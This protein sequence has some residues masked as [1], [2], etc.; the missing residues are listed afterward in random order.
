MPPKTTAARISQ[1]RPTETEMIAAKAEF[2]KMSGKQ[3]K[4]K[5]QSMMNFEKLYPDDD[6]RKSRG[7]VRSDYLLNFLVHQIR[8]KAAR[9]TISTTVSVEHTKSKN[10]TN[11]EW[12]SEQM[13]LKLGTT[14]LS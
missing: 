11:Y 6:V 9:N 10:S 1:L 7:Q 3:R 5:F 14:I 2:E 8:D 4:A 13:D 12:S